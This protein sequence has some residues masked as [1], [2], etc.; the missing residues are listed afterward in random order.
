M[1]Y[2]HCVLQNN[3]YLTLRASLLQS[4]KVL[5]EKLTGGNQLT[6]VNLQ[7]DHVC[8]RVCMLLNTDLPK[9]ANSV[10]CVQ[11]FNAYMATDRTIFTARRHVSAV[12]HSRANNA[13]R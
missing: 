3:Y 2:V 9:F 6:H 13:T 8:A 10:K 5:S 4:P 12:C 11:T 7:H 1:Y